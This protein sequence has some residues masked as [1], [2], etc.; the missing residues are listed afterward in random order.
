M[1]KGNDDGKE[2]EA[3]GA[4][5]RDAMTVQYHLMRQREQYHGTRD[6]VRP[7]PRERRTCASAPRGR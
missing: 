2:A 1:V 3:D 7:T 4:T 5:V 6:E